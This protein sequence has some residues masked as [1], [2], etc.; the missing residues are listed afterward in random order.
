[1][2]VPTTVEVSGGVE[3]KPVALSQLLTNI[4]SLYLLYSPLL[5][6]VCV[7]SGYLGDGFNRD[8]TGGWIC[9]S[10]QVG[11]KL[12]FSQ[13]MGTEKP[14]ETKKEKHFNGKCVFDFE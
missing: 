6:M 10:A 14:V 9:P 2:V 5:S 12:Y 8:K 7:H 13:N 4:L 3:N 1:M 11:L